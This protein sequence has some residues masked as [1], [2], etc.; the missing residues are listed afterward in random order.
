MYSHA[1][2]PSSIVGLFFL[3]VSYSGVFGS[4]DTQI[5]PNTNSI[6]IFNL[7]YLLFIYFI[8]T[9][10]PSSSSPPHL[11]M[12]RACPCEYAAYSLFLMT[13]FSSPS[14][15]TMPRNRARTPSLGCT[16]LSA[17]STLASVI[18]S[19]PFS[20]SFN[21]SFFSPPQYADPVCNVY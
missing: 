21:P 17:H 12:V 5:K 16:R 11:R 13:L 8:F 6:S 20:F 1:P 14:Y 9:S 10:I 4:V 18:S 7:L 15:T 2:L 19:D 3:P